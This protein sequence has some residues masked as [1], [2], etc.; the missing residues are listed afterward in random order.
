[1]GM[2]RFRAVVIGA[3]ASG[4]GGGDD[5]GGDSTATISVNTAV[6]GN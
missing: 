2:D 1:M 3:V 5:A 4:G 6:P